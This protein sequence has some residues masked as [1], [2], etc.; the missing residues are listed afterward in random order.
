MT[1]EATVQASLPRAAAP[2]VHACPI[3]GLSAAPSEEARVRSNLR[4]FAS[5][6]F[7][8][9]RCA[10][11]GSL[12]ARDEVDLAHYYAKYPF[13]A[14]A[15]PGERIMYDNLLRRLRRVGLTREQRVLDYGCGGGHFVGH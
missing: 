13:H 11:C 9:W 14:G 5:G 6:T 3:C 4:A 1:A 7:A 2:A 8:I 15:A 12:H 10:D